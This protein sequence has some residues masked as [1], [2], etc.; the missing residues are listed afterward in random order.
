VIWSKNAHKIITVLTPDQYINRFGNTFSEKV[1][2]EL[3]KYCSK[4]GA[5][6]EIDYNEKDDDIN[7]YDNNDCI[8]NS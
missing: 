2:L 8:S 4:E 1:R 5:E 3:L 7:N 6:E